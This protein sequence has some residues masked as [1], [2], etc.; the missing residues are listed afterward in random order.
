MATAAPF[1]AALKGLRMEWQC[2][3]LSSCLTHDRLTLLLSLCVCP[4]ELLPLSRGL[5][6]MQIP[7]LFCGT[8]PPL[9]LLSPSSHYIPLQQAVG[10]GDRKPAEWCVQHGGGKR[11]KT[12]GSVTELTPFPPHH[13]LLLIIS[14][15]ATSSCTG[16][17]T[18]V[19]ITGE[20][21]PALSEVSP[22]ER[23][24]H[25]QR[26]MLTHSFTHY[27]RLQQA[28]HHQ[29]TQVQCPHSHH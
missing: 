28:E 15:G 27:H 5:P 17:L 4:L 29:R 19:P 8:S 13:S 3:S 11:C 6:Q 18:C 22:L 1:R 26:R 24:T 10:R 20:D 2:S 14:T 25:T 7:R 12:I 16:Q 23:N 21:V 9:S